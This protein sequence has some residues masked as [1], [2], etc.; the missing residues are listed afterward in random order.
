MDPENPAPNYEPGLKGILKRSSHPIALV[1]HY[2]FKSLALICFIFLDLFI[3]DTIV[4]F[5]ITLLLCCADFWTVQNITGRLLVAL[6][7]RNQVEE[8]G[9]EHW[10]Y[11]SLNEKIENNK[12]DVWG[13]WLGLYSY[14]AL[15]ILMLLGSL[16]QL[17]PFDVRAF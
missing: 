16:I 12:I 4:N 14:V 10:V 6:R 1:F 13:F 8:D 2:L 3:E 17:S 7:W 11:E 15:W 9:T 5:I